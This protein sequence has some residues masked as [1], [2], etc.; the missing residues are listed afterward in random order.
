MDTSIEY[1]KMREKATEIQEHG[2]EEGDYHGLLQNGLWSAHNYCGESGF[3]GYLLHRFFMWWDSKQDL[4]F[5]SMAQLWLA[6]VMKEKYGKVW[7]SSKQ[8]WVKEET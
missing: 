1:I 3:V 5:P 8:D 2:F 4:P 7:D 6:F